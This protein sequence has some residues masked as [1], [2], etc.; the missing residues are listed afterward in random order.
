MHCWYLWK[1]VWVAIALR[2]TS[3]TM[4]QKSEDINRYNQPNNYFIIIHSYGTTSQSVAISYPFVTTN[5][6]LINVYRSKL[7][8]ILP[9]IR[10]SLF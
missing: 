6:F 3:T 9:I 2:L 4:F 5:F 10:L 1:C 7:N 8:T